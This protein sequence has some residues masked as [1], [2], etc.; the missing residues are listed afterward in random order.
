MEKEKR[1]D[2]IFVGVLK[3]AVREAF[4]EL[5][6]KYSDEHFYY[7]TLVLVEGQGCPVV[8]AMSEEALERV[9]QE[10]KEQYG[11]ADSE[12]S[13]RKELKWSYADSP[14][15]AYGEQ[16]F[17]EVQRMIGESDAEKSFIQEYDIKLN[18]MEKVMTDLDKEGIFGEGEQRKCMIVNAEVMPPDYTNTERAL[19]LNSGEVLKEW[20]EEAAEPDDDF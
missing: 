14:Y 4:K 10:Y 13:L 18:S 3:N 6:E 17:T 8:S 9:V 2:E 12:E 7:C 16:Y 11:Y 20:L 1:I 15:C 5:L 19:K